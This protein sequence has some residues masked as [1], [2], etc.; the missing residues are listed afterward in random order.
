[1]NTPEPIRVAR[2]GAVSIHRSV[3]P[4]PP[5]SACNLPARV[6]TAPGLGSGFGSGAFSFHGGLDA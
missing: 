5:L 1:M 3:A 6:D 2:G 4:T